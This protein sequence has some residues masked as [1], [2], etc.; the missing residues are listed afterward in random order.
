MRLKSAARRPRAP[1]IVSFRMLPGSE[2]GSASPARARMRK[3]N[4]WRQPGSARADAERRPHAQ[5]ACERRSSGAGSQ[6]ASKRR[7]K[8]DPHN[9]L[10]HAAVKRPGSSMASSMEGAGHQWTTPRTRHGGAEGRGPNGDRRSD[11][12]TC[13]R[14]VPRA[15]ARP[16]SLR[17]ATK[18]IRIHDGCARLHLRGFLRRQPAT[19][20]RGVGQQRPRAFD[21]SRTR[22]RQY[23]ERGQCPMGCARATRG[24][25]GLGSLI[26]RPGALRTR[27]PSH[28]PRHADCLG[29][30]LEPQRTSTSA[31]MGSAAAR[32]SQGPPSPDVH[33]FKRSPPKRRRRKA[34]TASPT[35]GAEKAHSRARRGVDNT[36]NRQE[37]RDLMSTCS[38]RFDSLWRAELRPRKF[39]KA[40]NAWHP[41]GMDWLDPCCNA[42]MFPTAQVVPWENSV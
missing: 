12:Q 10:A 5:V 31:S 9:A 27:R 8:K 11:D 2:I 28:A 40:C 41:R 24:S 36:L 18:A 4:P 32:Q 6:R 13:V 30:Q 29:V 14:K 23:V 34:T 7:D 33:G 21:A 20:N 25:F 42:H 35:A 15:R 26:V 39:P 17:A 1:T 22:E 16:S 19:D 37:P 3:R 38:F